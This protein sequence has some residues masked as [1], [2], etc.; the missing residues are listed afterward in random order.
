M[1]E[2]EETWTWG[3][4]WWECAFGNIGRLRERIQPVIGRIPF[5]WV[6]LIKNFIPHIVILLFFNLCT[7]GDGAYRGYT[8]RPYQLLGMMSFTF[9]IFLVFL[10]LLV[11]Q[12]YKSFF[13]PQIKEIFQ[14]ETRKSS[15]VPSRSPEKSS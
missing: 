8:I 15:G 4:I 7:S 3:S 12:V 5:I 11:P 14:E 2:E 13:T 9:A 6:V 10:G 1:A